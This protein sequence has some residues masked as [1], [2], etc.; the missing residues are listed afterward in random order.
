MKPVPEDF[1]RDD[2]VPAMPGY[3]PKL[4]ARRIDGK[5]IVGL[6]DDELHE[7][8]AECSRVVDQLVAYTKRK[9]SENGWAIENAFERVASAVRS[10]IASREWGLTHQECEWVLQK[11]RHQFIDD[12]T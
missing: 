9:A 3:Q 5:Y 12:S 2:T 7:R 8:Y 1:P 10:K 11:V 4:G 6:T